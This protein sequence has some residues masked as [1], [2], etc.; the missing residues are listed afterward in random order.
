M[1]NVVFQTLFHSMFLTLGIF[2][3]YEFP[4]LG[5]NENAK[6]FECFA[7]RTGTNFYIL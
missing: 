2:F 3:V 7:S 5:S 6:I 1:V 4:T